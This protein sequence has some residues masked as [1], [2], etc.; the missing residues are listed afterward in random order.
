MPAAW[1]CT[2]CMLHLGP[3]C[4]RTANHVAAGPCQAE[5][6]GQACSELAVKLPASY[7]QRP[8]AQLYQTIVA[9]AQQPELA[10]PETPSLKVRTQDI[11]QLFLSGCGPSA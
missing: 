4:T 3:P 7:T 11:V 8:A 5:R 9:T 6:I 1:D 2:L 10:I